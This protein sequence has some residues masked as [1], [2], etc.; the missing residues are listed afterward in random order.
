[1]Y[2]TVWDILKYLLGTRMLKGLKVYCCHLLLF[3]IYWTFAQPDG[4]A[5]I[6]HSYAQMFGHMHHYPKLQRHLPYLPIFWQ[7]GGSKSANFSL[8]F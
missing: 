2:R 7:G 6:H 5:A 1:M 3:L 4:A 8:S